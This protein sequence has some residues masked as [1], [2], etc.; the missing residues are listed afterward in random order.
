MNIMNK[1]TGKHMRRLMTLLAMNSLWLLAVTPAQAQEI[2]QR[3]TIYQTVNVRSGPDTQFEIVTKLEAGNTVIV[4]GRDSEA[5]RW[6]RIVL[7][8]VDDVPFGW[9]TSFSVTLEDDPMRLPVVS[10]ETESEAPGSNQPPDAESANQVLVVAYGRVNIRSG[11][12]ITYDVVG[13]LDMDEEA[14]VLARSNRQNDWLYI[15]A[16]ERATGW[17][18]FFTVTVIG[19]PSDLPVRVLD[20]S[21]TELVPPSS[22]IT[23][24]FN[25]H[26]RSEPSTVQGEVVGIVNFGSQA[27]PLAQTENGRW[28]YVIYEDTEG[29]ALTQLFEIRDEQ[30]L[31]VPV[32]QPQGDGTFDLTPVPEPTAETT[33][34]AE[35]MPEVTAEASE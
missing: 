14:E 31:H 3:G 8:D 21:N 10:P 20:G 12:D 30:Q 29:W 6:L 11:P 2:T 23:T 18:A 7:D 22:L 5:T 28:L 13:Q 33:V 9:V 34:E 26:L 32:Y 35:V 16:E 24:R 17:V 1:H 25:V 4:N 15:E 27:T 19:D